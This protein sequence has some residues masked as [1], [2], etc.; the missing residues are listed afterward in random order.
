MKHEI[1]MDAV[2]QFCREL[3]EDERSRATIEKYRRD[4]KK[5][6]D[7]LGE[8]RIIDKERMIGFK[9]ELIK[10]YASAS[11]NSILAAV[12]S[13]LK[14]R[15]WY[16]CVVKSVRIQQESF[17]SQ[18]RELTKEE[19]YRLLE[20]A[21]KAGR[22]RL[23]LLMQ[24]LCSTGIRVSELRFIT[25]ESLKIQRAVVQLKGK[26]RSVLLP[27]ILCRRL[28]EYAREKGISGG[29]IFVTKGGRP[30]D[31]S[32]ILHEMKSV[33]RAAGVEK[34]KVFPHNLRHLFACTYYEK[35]K[36]LFHLA[37]LLGHSSV[38]TTR[39]YTKGSGKA[40]VEKI[41]KLKLA[42]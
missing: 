13:F 12:N 26:I 16:D 18:E 38:N 37:D 17:R 10:T 14:R 23:H 3:A 7:Y 9:N 11:V 1:G 8:D 32:N 27:A 30:M 40:Q 42:V 31:R 33:C 35:E 34:S 28:K 21:E 24:T 4:V 19:Y 22:K 5:L 29:S 25:V 39:L 6:M 15:G 2:E 36:D 41:E 20:A